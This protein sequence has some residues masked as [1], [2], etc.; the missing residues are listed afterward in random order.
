MYLEDTT[1][2]LVDQT[3]DTLDTT[4]TR[5][6]SDGWLSDAL[7]VVTEDLPVTLG[8]SFSKT[9]ASLASARHLDKCAKKAECA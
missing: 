3:R 7:D 1:G 9:L 6:T 4:T 8:A 2:F 5:E